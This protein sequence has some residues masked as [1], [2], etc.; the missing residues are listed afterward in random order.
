[1]GSKSDFPQILQKPARGTSQDDPCQMVRLIW[2]HVHV[3]ASGRAKGCNTQSP[4]YTHTAERQPCQNKQ[5]ECKP[6][7]IWKQGWGKC[8]QNAREPPKNAGSLLDPAGSLLDPCPAP[9]GVGAIWVKIRISPKSSKNQLR[10]PLMKPP[11]QWHSVYL[12]EM[13]KWHMPAH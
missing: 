7:W 2:V 12:G 1:M 9:V 8:A 3:F 6:S 10:G 13:V 11:A 5:Q 4:M